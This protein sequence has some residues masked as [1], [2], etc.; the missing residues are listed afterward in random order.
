MARK[1]KPVTHK[2]MTDQTAL[3]LLYG[4]PERTLHERDMREYQT[5]MGNKILELPGVLLGAEMG[6][7]KT[8]SSLWGMSKLIRVGEVRRPLIVAPLRVSEETW[9]EEFRT[10]D[11]ARDISFRVVTGTP[12]EREAALAYSPAQATIINRENL[13]WLHDRFQG[14]GWPFDMLIYDEASRLKR[15]MNRVYQTKDQIRS[16]KKAALSELG[17]IKAHRPSFKRIV[18]LSGTP[19]PNGLVDLYGPI[20]ALEDGERLGTS[21]TAF[22][23]RWFIEDKYTKEIHAR[24]GAE[25][26]IMGLIKDIF[27]SLRSEDY[28][29]LPPLVPVD[30]HVKL[31]P[32]AMKIYKEFE[33]E[34]AIELVNNA[35]DPEYIEAVN[36]G[37][38][39]GKLLQLANGS[40]YTSE[41][42]AIKVHD[43]KL[44]ALESIMEEANGRPVIV[45]YSFQFDKAAI[46]KKFP[47]CRVYGD[48][49]NDMRD[50]NAGR[51]KMLLT[52]PASAGHGLN[53]QFGSNIAV[54]YGLTWS[55]ELYLQFIKRLHRSGQKHDR[56]FL[57]RIIAQGTA[58]EN[59]LNVL[60]SRTITQ[61][62]ITDAVKARLGRTW[63]LAA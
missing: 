62:R 25:Q 37:V 47:Y 20:S 11:F 26:E 9:P 17:I 29:T 41:K 30:H 45:A 63:R 44:A 49:P 19:A 50:W 4:P 13:R 43:A 28:L 48:S 46:L 54:W 58:D 24:V 18:E 2:I 14:R 56:V 60:K 10:W 27:F 42:E 15:G 8:G 51:I 61:D 52:H 32:R 21:M 35:G 38:L 57:H 7:G 5:W 22:K 59:V 33:R 34:S 1:K 3:D 23:N 55:A 39:T 6:L 12:E 40:I 16:G 31:P 53:F 36:N